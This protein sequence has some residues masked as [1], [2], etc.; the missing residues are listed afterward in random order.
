[1]IRN[2]I[3][4]KFRF[5]LIGEIQ[6]GKVKTEMYKN[7][8]LVDVFNLIYNEDPE[9]VRLNII[10]WYAD[11]YLIKAPSNTIFSRHKS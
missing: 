6:D 11:N 9:E 1:M 3:L 7:N 5:K 4:G 10:K 2:Y 8:Q